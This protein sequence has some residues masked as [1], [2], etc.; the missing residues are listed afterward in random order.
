VKSFAALAVR[1]KASEEKAIGDGLLIKPA[2]LQML[3]SSS[4]VASLTYMELADTDK[5]A[6]VPAAITFIFTTMV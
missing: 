4:V 1:I 3:A 6:R 5:S 2:D